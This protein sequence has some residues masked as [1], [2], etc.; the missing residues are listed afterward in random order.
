M[1][2]ILTPFACQHELVHVLA[3]KHDPTDLPP[4]NES[5]S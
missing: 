2:D 5:E 1:A 4:E 3:I